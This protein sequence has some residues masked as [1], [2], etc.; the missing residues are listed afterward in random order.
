[1]PWPDTIAQNKARC[2]FIFI[3]I[4]CVIPNRKHKMIAIILEKKCLRMWRFHF[5]KCPWGF[6]VLLNYLKYTMKKQARLYVHWSNKPY[7]CCVVIWI[8]EE[9]SILIFLIFHIQT[10]SSVFFFFFGNNQNQGTIGFG[11]CKTLKNLWFYGRTIS[12]FEFF[13]NVKN[14]GYIPNLV[15]LNFSKLWEPWLN[16]KLEPWHFSIEPKA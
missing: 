1:M 11:H 16:T 15:Y 8:F 9:P 2:L 3:F 14:H 12:L 7:Q 5:S 10:S 6:Y 4:F 13:Q